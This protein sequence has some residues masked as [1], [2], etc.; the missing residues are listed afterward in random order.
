VSQ[1]KECLQ[2][3][4]SAPEP[5]GEERTVLVAAG[6]LPIVRQPDSPPPL[7]TPR[8]KR[9]ETG[10]RFPSGS[11][12]KTDVLSHNQ[13]PGKPGVPPLAQPFWRR[14]DL[15]PLMLMVVGTT[16]VFGALALFVYLKKWQPVSPPSPG[17]KEEQPAYPLG[18]DGLQKKE[19]EGLKGV[20]RPFE[21]TESSPPIRPKA[22]PPIVP[23]RQQLDQL[24]RNFQTAYE[25]QDMSSLQQL[26]E[27]GQ[28]RQVFLGMM[29]ANY[30]SIR[31][32]IHDVKI[33]AGQATA[34]LIHDELIDQSGERVAPDPIL[35]SIAIK[36]RKEGDHWGRV[37]W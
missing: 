17:P 30:S 22:I 10:T 29:I 16:L 34:T 26:S 32:S 28:D 25:R 18:S 12:E 15:F 3:L 23:S 2:I 20:E 5:S 37:I 31:T 11:E 1:L 19:T 21:K 24:L 27:I 9:D 14:Y 8:W 4:P 7:R 33:S 35:R 36:V 13:S 6:E